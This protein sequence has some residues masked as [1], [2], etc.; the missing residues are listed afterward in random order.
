MKFCNLRTGKELKELFWS[1]KFPEHSFCRFLIFIVIATPILF[2]MIGIPVLVWFTFA[3]FYPNTTGIVTIL[4]I[5]RLFV[6]KNKP[7]F[8]IAFE[9]M[10]KIVCRIAF[11]R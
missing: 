11:G 1:S 6:C 7:W 3:E 10:G 2:V 8:I 5:I 4:Y 9:K